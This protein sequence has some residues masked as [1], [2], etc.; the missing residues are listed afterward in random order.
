[1][2]L[3]LTTKSCIQL[4]FFLVQGVDYRSQFIF[5]RMVTLLS[6]LHLL[7]PLDTTFI[8]KTNFKPFGIIIEKAL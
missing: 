2:I 5:L 1:M 4:E 3:F 7:K 8:M 6:P